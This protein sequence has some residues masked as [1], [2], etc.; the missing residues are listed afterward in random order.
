MLLQG[1]QD[2]VQEMWSDIETDD[3]KRERLEKAAPEWKD[4]EH[5]VFSFHEK[6]PTTI[7]EALSNIKLKRVRLDAMKKLLLDAWESEDTALHVFQ[8][9]LEFSGVRAHEKST[10]AD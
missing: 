1:A 7:E 10:A 5:I 6:D 8:E 2:V 3:A 9:A 4:S